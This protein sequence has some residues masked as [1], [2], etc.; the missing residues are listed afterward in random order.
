MNNNNI[1]C[2]PLM[3]DNGRLFTDYRQ[4]SDI[5]S[6]MKSNNNIHSNVELKN[7][8][9]QNGSTLRTKFKA[10]NDSKLQCVPTNKFDNNLL[11]SCKQ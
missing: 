10:N 3:S 2:P 4:Q 6:M 11:N 8:L 7:F 9:T 5:I 1:N